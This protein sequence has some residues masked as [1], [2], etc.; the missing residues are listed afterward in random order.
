MTAAS[1]VARKPVTIPAGVEVKIQGQELAIKGP[2]GHLTYP[3]H[4]LVQVVIEDGLIRIKNN[5]QHGHIR[6][7]SG[8][9]LRNAITGTARANIANI[10]EGVTKAFERKLLLVGV[11]YKAQV[12]GKF[13]GL[14]L[15]YSH[16]IDFP[17]PEGI[18]IETPSPTEITVSGI[19]P[20]QVGLVSAKIRAYR[21][22]EPYKGKGIKYSDE[23]I[24]RKETK[25]K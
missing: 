24:E 1:R 17:I 14:T 22:P 16:P 11:G 6:S 21:S 25:K 7:G 13:L 9:R 4:P 12:K 15:G 3:I 20:D 5:E 23:I 2:K 8:S 10:V 18:K 19:D